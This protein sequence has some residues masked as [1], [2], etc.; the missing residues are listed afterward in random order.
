MAD[1][2]SVPSQVVKSNG[3][4][5]DV[6]DVSATDMG[7]GKVICTFYYNDSIPPN[8]DVEVPGHPDWWCLTY[9]TYGKVECMS[10]ISA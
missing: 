4:Q 9:S 1:C 8:T 7:N 2:A 6:Y 5:A 10:C 3:L